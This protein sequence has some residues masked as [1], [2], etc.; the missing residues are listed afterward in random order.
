MHAPDMLDALERSGAYDI[1]VYGHTHKLDVRGGETLVVNPGECGGWLTGRCT[2]AVLDT[3]Y[4]EVE[5][6]EL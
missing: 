2:V 3:E 5:V 4:M 1:I 6:R